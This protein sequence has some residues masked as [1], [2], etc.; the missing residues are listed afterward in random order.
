MDASQTRIQE[1]I[2]DLS[3]KNE[4]IR[5]GAAFA[6]AR[7]GTPAVDLLI[8][9]LDD[10]D[11]V[12][13]L[14]AAWALGRIG[15]PR[16]VVGLISALRDGDWAVRMRAAEALGRLRAIKALD[17]LML[18][19]R[20]EKPEVRRHAIGALT[21]IADP[22]SADRLGDALKDPDWRVRM[23]AALALTA[24]GDPKSLGYLQTAT[25]D[26]NEFVQRIANAITRK[27]EGE[28][29]LKETKAG[30]LKDLPDGSMKGIQVQGKDILLIN[31]KGIV[32]AI[33]NTCTHKGCKLSDGTLEN[34]RV[35][36]PCHGS[37]FDIR[38]G[39]VIK[40]PAK[41]PESRYD[42]TIRNEEI[43]ITA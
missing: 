33:G 12:V 31:M 20:D 1:L 23:G 29:C 17:A 40:G 2:K 15:D 43:F 13:R 9:A 27:K 41:T 42:V 28:V 4:D 10:K 19:L 11:S 18:T 35:R 6:L 34:E 14:R 32:S 30:Q 36:C 37:V 39:N 38:T 7:I 8:P 22:A 24:I 16:A 5:W 21:L 25:C 26:E 3:H